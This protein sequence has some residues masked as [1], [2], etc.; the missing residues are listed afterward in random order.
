MTHGDPA[1][2]PLVVFFTRQHPP[3]VTGFFAFKAFMQE[4]MVKA[5]LPKDF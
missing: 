2:K 5:L 3:E 1:E 4:V